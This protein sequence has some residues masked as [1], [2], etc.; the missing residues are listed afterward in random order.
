M[1]RVFRVSRAYPAC[2]EFPEQ[3][4]PTIR[5]A[6]IHLDGRAIVRS[7]AFIY[8]GKIKK[9]EATIFAPSASDARYEPPPTPA[10]ATP[11]PPHQTPTPAPRRPPRRPRL[12]P[13]RQPLDTNRRPRLHPPRRTLRTLHPRCSCQQARRPPQPTTQQTRLCKSPML[14]KQCPVGT[15]TAAI[16][17]K[18]RENFSPY[19]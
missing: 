10:P 5:H 11:H 7:P 19:I 13:P 12:H 14:C 4:R 8:A 6:R 15:A 9:N 3:N 16:S 1:H 17:S 2:L 18:M